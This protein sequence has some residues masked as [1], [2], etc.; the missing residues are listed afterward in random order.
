MFDG[1]IKLENAVE[2]I[3]PIGNI[4]SGL[5]LELNINNKNYK[6]LVDTGASAS[7]LNDQIFKDM[8]TSKKK[9]KMRD[10]TGIED[11][12]DLFYLDFKI[13]KNQF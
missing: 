1:E 4:D 3:Y 13:G 2:Y 10:T 7:V 8:I 9:V 5:L 12:K 6:F 11:E